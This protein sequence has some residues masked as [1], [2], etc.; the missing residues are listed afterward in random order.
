MNV[1]CALGTRGKPYPRLSCMRCEF[2]R[3]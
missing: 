1:V 3:G 2:L